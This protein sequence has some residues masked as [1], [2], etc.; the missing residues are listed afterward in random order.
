[1]AANPEELIQR[2]LVLAPIGRDAP[3]AAHHLAE[4]NLTCVICVD[5]ADLNAK[6]RE[7]AAAA[8]VTEE[9]FLAG[10]HPSS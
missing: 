4:S 1:M 6:L 8:L 9:A 3:A 5:L 2:I 7:G 10:R